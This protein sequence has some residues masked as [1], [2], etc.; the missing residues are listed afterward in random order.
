MSTPA[1]PTPTFDKNELDTTS[2]E[3]QPV[4]PPPQAPVEENITVR[5][6]TTL[7]AFSAVSYSI[8]PLPVEKNITVKKRAASEAFSV[9]SDSSNTDHD[10]YTTKVK[11]PLVVAEV[12]PEASDKDKYNRRRVKNN[13]ASKQSR[14]S[15]K[16]KYVDMDGEALRLEAENEEL[17]RRAEKLEELAKEMKRIL[18]EKMVQ[19]K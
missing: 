8:I 7:E 3:L 12:K 18:I 14:L 13:V 5:K 4:I 2:Q 9:A 17:R 10:D 19:K 6:R 1:E 16:Q 15:R 11:K